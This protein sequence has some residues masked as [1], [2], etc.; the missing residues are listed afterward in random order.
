M[1]PETSKHIHQYGEHNMSISDREIEMLLC[2]LREHYPNQ[3]DIQII[4]DCIYYF[5]GTYAMAL[6]ECLYNIR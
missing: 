1:L 4:E 5:G 3:T 2:M 6:V